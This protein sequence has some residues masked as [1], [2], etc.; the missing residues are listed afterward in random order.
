MSADPKAK[1]TSNAVIWA[2][3]LTI[4]ASLSA[5]WTTFI[6]RAFRPI[7]HPLLK[8]FPF[9]S[10]KTLR[11]GRS[12]MYGLSIVLVKN[13]F[14][15]MGMEWKDTEGLEKAFSECPPGVRPL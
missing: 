15:R 9:K 1:E 3:A 4:N 11:A 8:A 6:P 10:L 7:T 13:A 5:L 12:M 14:E 2:A